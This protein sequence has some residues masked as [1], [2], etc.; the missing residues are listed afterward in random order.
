MMMII[1]REVWKVFAVSILACFAFMMLGLNRRI[2]RVGGSRLL[3]LRALD[4]AG[5]AAAAASTLSLASQSEV[6]LESRVTCESV[7]PDYENG[8]VVIVGGGI[9]GVYAA[10][11]LVLSGKV[12]PKKILI[13]EKSANLGGR[14]LSQ[15]SPNA[16]NENIDSTKR[17]DQGDFIAAAWDREIEL[18][19]M[20]LY[21]T[22][23]RAL[24]LVDSLRLETMP[25]SSCPENKSKSVF[26]FDGRRYNRSRYT[27]MR[28]DERDVSVGSAA[29]DA[30]D[31]FVKRYPSEASYFSKEDS[32]QSG[33]VFAS[34][35][36]RNMSYREFLFDWLKARKGDEDAERVV[37]AAIAFAGYDFL[38]DEEIS[39]ANYLHGHGMYSMTGNEKPV[40]VKGGFQAVVDKL[41]AESGAT[42]ATSANVEAIEI[43]KDSR[44]WTLQIRFNETDCVKRIRAQTLVLAT[45]A[46]SSRMLL[47]SSANTELRAAAAFI[48]DSIK[49]YALFKGFLTYRRNWWKR[50]GYC[51]GKSVDD[52]PLNNVFYFSENTLLVYNAHRVAER[53][54]G[55]FASGEEGEGDAVLQ[56]IT[57]I[58]SLHGLAP[59]RTNGANESQFASFEEWPLSV[60]YKF[61]I[62]GSY[63]WRRGVDVPKTLAQLQRMMFFRRRSGRS[64]PLYMLGDS[65]S[66]NQGWIEG[67]L[68]SAERVVAAMLRDIEN[69]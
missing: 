9:G 22:H 32:A 25:F 42:I 23:S 49:T 55:L 41:S 19:G 30:I 15:S 17:F 68:E 2:S 48:R 54:N 63:K 5:S 51:R 36:L 33:G 38:F 34:Q 47:E 37:N 31:A 58:Q 18:G 26:M 52:G 69:Q 40:H 27:S 20:R 10:R 12:D 45:N 8:G 64:T 7:L 61:W 60:H 6:E 29:G 39:A 62:D 44:I 21:S 14:L 28:L 53:W 66:Y 13:V 46:Y 59:P 57:S 24:S 16:D 4:N 35:K 3:R 43:E 65:F 67:A 56:M 50:S 1:S 11:S